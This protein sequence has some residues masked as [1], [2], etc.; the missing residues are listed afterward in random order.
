MNVAVL[1]RPYMGQPLP[2]ALPDAGA[3][4]RPVTSVAEA[5]PADFLQRLR[6]Q[7]EALRQGNVTVETFGAFWDTASRIRCYDD[8]IAETYH[9]P[10]GREL[11]GSDREAAI[12]LYNMRSADAWKL[13][14]AA[15]AGSAGRLEN[16]RLA[17]D[18]VRFVCE[19]FGRYSGICELDI[20]ADELDQL[21][22]A[23]RRLCLT[24]GITDPVAYT[25]DQLIQ[26]ATTRLELHD[27]I[28]A[29]TFDTLF[30][31]GRQTRRLAAAVGPVRDLTGIAPLADDSEAAEH[32]TD[33]A[34]AVVRPRS[35][36]ITVTQEFQSAAADP[37]L[38]GEPTWD[39]PGWPRDP[40]E[41]SR[42][43]R[44]YVRSHRAER[45]GRKWIRR[46]VA[47][48]GMAAVMGATIGA[49]YLAATGKVPWHPGAEAAVI[50][51]GAALLPPVEPHLPPLIETPQLPPAQ[52]MINPDQYVWNV[53]HAVAPG[54]EL[55]TINQAIE[56]ANGQ[57]H[58]YSIA[59]ATPDNYQI[60]YDGITMTGDQRITLN[61]IIVDLT[62]DYSQA[63]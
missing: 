62:T 32:A 12:L 9:G 57:G 36:P 43:Y 17:I 5:L 10:D 61:Q 14:D 25:L 22:V 37:P 6:Q 2:D 40:L 11:A 16:Q 56:I 24:L 31:S 55:P 1:D 42:P 38:E 46:L 51:T 45:R 27:A 49:V 53:A 41:P 8:G 59:Y 63:T 35:E 34:R 60:M 54:Q 44:G 58:N 47:A 50:D 4:L 20:T 29:G 30:Q 52:F 39:G 21:D 23:R 19:I 15:A 48:V 3:P 18:D 26:K 28:T 13:D 7:V 33:T